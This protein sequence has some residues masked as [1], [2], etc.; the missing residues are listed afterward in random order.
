MKLLLTMLLGLFVLGS[1]AFVVIYKPFEKREGEVTIGDLI[2]QSRRNIPGTKINGLPK[3]NGV[4]PAPADYEG[5]LLIPVPENEQKLIRDGGSEVSF[6]TYVP[7]KVPQGFSLRP[8]SVS[9]GVQNNI[10]VFQSF[11]SHSNGD[12]LFIYQY[13]LNEYLTGSGQT[14]AEFTNGKEGMDVDG[15]KIYVADT[16][17]KTAGR[18][19]YLQGITAIAGTTMIRI[20]YFGEKKLSSSDLIELAV[21]LAR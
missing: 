15:K 3:E 6:E 18:F 7:T 10:T 9:H 4:S 21:S 1:A 16:G 13:P 11:F 17:T 8:T 2:E 12:N 5:T 20:E 19:Q 14:L